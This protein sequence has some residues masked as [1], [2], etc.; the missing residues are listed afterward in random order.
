MVIN[1]KP[2]EKKGDG[3]LSMWKEHE[4]EEEGG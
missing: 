2:K 3:V 4:G 1:V